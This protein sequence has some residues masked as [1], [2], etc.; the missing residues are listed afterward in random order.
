MPGWGSLIIDVSTVS[1]DTLIAAVALLATVGAWL[2]DRFLLRRRRLVYRVQV[3]TPIGVHPQ[4]HKDKVQVAVT[5]RTQE[6]ADPSIVL[7]RIDNPGVDIEPE[8]FENE[9]RFDFPDRGGARKYTGMTVVTLDGITPDAAH[10][11]S[12]TYKFWEIEY[13][14]TFRAPEK[15]S[16]QQVFLDYLLSERSR[17]VLARDGL[18]PCAEVRKCS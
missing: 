2:V 14:Y 15:D 5:Y 3:D 8:H 12:G 13:A 7:I 18:I 1:L 9:F 10:V 4:A 17:P 16:L 11:A 6:V